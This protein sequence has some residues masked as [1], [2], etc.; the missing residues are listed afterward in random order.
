MISHDVV[1][2]RMAGPGVRYWEMARAL[3]AK[4]EITLATPGASLLGEGFASH[5][6]KPGDWASIALFVARAD[7]VLLHGVGLADFPRLET[8]GKPL[9][10]EASYPYTFEGLQFLSR[11]PADERMSVAAQN[12]EIARQAA[13]VGDFFVCACQRQRDY[14]IGVLDAVGR[15]NPDT[16]GEDPTLY[17]LIDIVPF[18]LPARSPEHTA[19]AIKGVIPGIGLMDRV[20]LWGGGLWQWLDPL[21]LVRAIARVAKERP[22]VRLVFPATLHPNPMVAEMPML[23]QTMEL[24]DQLGLTDR[25]TFFG[26]WVP[27]EFW[28]NYLLE[29]D[30][31]ASLHFDTLETRFAFRTRM[32]DYIWAG[33]PMVVTGGDETSQLV[34]RYG[35]GEVVKPGDDEA[36]AAAI[37]RLLDTP[38]LREAYSEGFEQV[39]PHFTWE[40]ACEPITR[41]C[42]Q[43]RLAPDRAVER[44]PF[45]MPAEKALSAEVG[46]LRVQ[47]EQQHSEIARLQEQY[48]Q[49]HS[50][51]G[52]L[53][54]LVD[55]YERGRFMRLMRRVHAWRRKL[56]L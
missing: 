18:G 53:Q 55:G 11:Y 19:P 25:V 4:L 6:Y 48:E 26:D 34:T 28:P 10:I 49:Q 52:Q 29:A 1:D 45:Q 20:V 3:S 22:N 50:E 27:Y 9:I 31:G 54:A 51:I 8:C 42:Q 38:N 21:S 32:L 13:L 33:L 24:S 12:L 7:V 35:L 56:G 17:G 5:A 23:R 15:I 40:R 46:Q 16:Y 14:W 36:I 47:C 39:R 41:F 30:I 37:L 44:M 43:P 2:R